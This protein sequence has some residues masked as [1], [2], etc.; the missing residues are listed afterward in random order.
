MALDAFS[1]FVHLKGTCTCCM[2][3]AI[4]LSVVSAVSSDTELFSG[5][6]H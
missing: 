5:K 6:V 2:V 1:G 4:T 3:L